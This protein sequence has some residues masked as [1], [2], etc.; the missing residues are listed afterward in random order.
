MKNHNYI[1]YPQVLQMEPPAEIWVGDHLNGFDQYHCNSILDKL[2]ETQHE[3]TIV[4]TGYIVNDS[5]QTNYPKLDIRYRWL[6]WMWQSVENL[7]HTVGKNYKNFICSFNGT[8]H[9]GRQFLTSALYKHGWFSKQYCSKN[10]TA[11]QNRIDGNILQFHNEQQ[12]RFSRKFI[13]N[14]SADSDDFYNTVH[15]FDYDSRT[16]HNANVN[17]LHHKISESFVNI[18]SE[19]M[20]TSYHPFVTEKFLYSIVCR[21]LFVTYAQPGWH[22]HVQKYYGFKPYTKIFDYAFDQ[23]ANPVD[24]LLALLAMVGKFSQLTTDDWND[25]YLMEKDTIDYNYDH[26]MSQ[27]YLQHLKE[28]LHGRPWD[29]HN[30]FL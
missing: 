21:G 11:T 20:A 22:R 2:S 6:R 18:V 27:R 15:G 29:T 17:V 19:T 4:W 3:K 8:E 23:V 10:F 7:D 30:N 26:Y 5:V 14:D 9:I 12:S 13:V 28:S 1:Y 16:D 25:L 24:R